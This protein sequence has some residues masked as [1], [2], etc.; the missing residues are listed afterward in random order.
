[1]KIV[2]LIARI[3]LGLVFLIFGLNKFHAFIPA[4]V[5]PGLGG[6]FM[7]ALFVSHYLLV[8]G[9][10]EVICGIL[11]L[12]NRYIPLSL[13]LI[14]PVVVNIFLFDAFLS[15]SGL[16]IGCLLVIFWLIVYK[17]VRPAFAG[18]F[19]QKA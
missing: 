17:S 19:L 5:P 7:G 11:F 10:L 3:L 18:I 12:I 4:P 9:A 13:V 14:G 8:I 1:M 2:T 6:Q 16:P 15:P